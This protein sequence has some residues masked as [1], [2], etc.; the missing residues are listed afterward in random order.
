MVV[1]PEKQ[2]GAK[3]PF[4][5][6]MLNESSS[7]TI[8][9]THCIL[10]RRPTELQQWNAFSNQNMC[11]WA[12]NDNL[13]SHWQS[14]TVAG[15]LPSIPLV[16]TFGISLTSSSS[17]KTNLLDVLIFKKKAFGTFHIYEKQ[18]HLYTSTLTI[19]GSI[20]QTQ[21]LAIFL[22]LHLSNVSGPLHMTALL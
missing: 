15:P 17:F 20:L 21:K 19:W 22:G 12:S 9:W 14:I 2:Q 13:P 1:K 6:Q 18:I 3:K 5:P 11:L 10:F 4:V 7:N 8:G 16:L